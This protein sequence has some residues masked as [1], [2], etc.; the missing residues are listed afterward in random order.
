MKQLLLLLS[1][2]VASTAFAQ[3]KPGK[4]PPPP[5]RI[6]LEET[7]QPH[8]SEPVDNTKKCFGYNT[9]TTKGD[10]T[11]VKESLL[12]FG[13]NGKLGRIVITTYD[14]NT[15]EK[16]KA[17]EN[18]RIF[19]PSQQLQFIE[20]KYKIEGKMLIFTPDKTDKFPVRKFTLQINPNSNTVEKVLDNDKNEWTTANCFE[21]IISL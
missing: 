12:E 14:Y 16:K 1:T 15:E 20:G 19:A 17:K 18:G 4:I 7:P 10:T 2:L 6:K 5:Q 3:V 9:E 13:G 21:P 8:K 11:F